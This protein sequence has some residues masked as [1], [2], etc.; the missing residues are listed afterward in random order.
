MNLY[1]MKFKP[2]F[3]ERIWG[4]NKIGTF[5]GKEI[6][7]GKKVGESW[8]LADL[9]LDKSKITNGQFA[10][11]TI[12]E[13]LN[14]YPLEITG[15]TQF[16]GPFPLLIKILDAQDFLSVQVHPDPQTCRRRGEG[17]P[18]TE[19]WYIIDCQPEC[20]I[21]KGLKQ[22]VTKEDFSRAITKGTCETL[23]EK[24]KVNKGECH[25]LPAGTPHA[26]GPGLLIAEIQTPSDTTY[27]VFDW[28]RLDSDGNSRQLHIEDALESIHFDSSDD[29]LSVSSQGRLVDSEWFTVDKGAVQPQ[30]DIILEPGTMKVLFFLSGNGVVHS[31]QNMVKYNP[32]DTVLIPHNCKGRLEAE[33]STCYLQTVTQ[34]ISK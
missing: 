11:K 31:E 27:R 32:G 10:G 5:F 2:I 33:I 13:I 17:D 3:K 14:L 1:P 20:C 22:G 34:R 30:S 23:L 29:N 4:G 16:K 9:P 8:E 18:K 26:I 12:D 24:V 21:Y 25:F 6:P 28:N 15:N 7:P 19:C